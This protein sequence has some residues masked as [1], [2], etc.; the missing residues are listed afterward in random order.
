MTADYGYLK[1]WFDGPAE[2]LSAFR[3]IAEVTDRQNRFSCGLS[4]LDD[5]DCDDQ[6]ESEAI[7]Y[8]SIDCTREFLSRLTATLPELQF[9]GTLEHSWPVLPCRR[10]I[11]EFS[12]SQGALL[13]NERQEEESVDDLF[14]FPDDGD[15]DDDD[16]EDIEIPLTPY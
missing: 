12:S 16:E 5:L 11:V 7:S 4:W 9:E 3:A 15:G 10:T 13:W 2:V 14:L 1:C 8:D 6:A